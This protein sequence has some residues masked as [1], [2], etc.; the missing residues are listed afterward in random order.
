MARIKEPPW[1]AV[2]S[3]SDTSALFEVKT[4]FGNYI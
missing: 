2:I 3:K 1:E 4:H